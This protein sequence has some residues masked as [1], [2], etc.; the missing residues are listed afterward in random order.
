MRFLSNTPAINTHETVSTSR[1]QRTNNYCQTK[2]HVIPSMENWQ[3]GRLHHLAG[4]IAHCTFPNLLCHNNKTG[5]F[6]LVALM[7]HHIP[8]L[9]SSRSTWYRSLSISA[10][11]YW[12]FGLCDRLTFKA[13]RLLHVPPGLTLWRLTTYIYVVPHS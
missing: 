2:S 10:K 3:Q 4:R 6:I 12:L 5:Q 8:T 9:I 1:P 13:Y 7:A 11:Q